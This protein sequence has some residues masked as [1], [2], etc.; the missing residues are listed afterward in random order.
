LGEIGLIRI[1]PY[2]RAQP[3]FFVFDI[4]DKSRALPFQSLANG[5][6]IQCSIHGCCSF[7]MLMRLRTSPSRSAGYDLGQW[8]RLF[9]VCQGDAIELGAI[10]DR[11][12]R[13]GDMHLALSPTHF[14]DPLRRELH[15][16]ASS[17]PPVST[18][19]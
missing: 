4:P 3:Q 9:L 1:L 2:G 10:L 15:F 12:L 18:M 11:C 6:Y 19:M 7:S 14:A 16:S 5:L 8:R 17:Q 13:E